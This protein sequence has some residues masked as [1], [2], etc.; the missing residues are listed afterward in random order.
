MAGGTLRRHCKE[1]VSLEF[2]LE[3]DTHCQSPGSYALHAVATVKLA[4]HADRRFP[5]FRFRRYDNRAAA[6]NYRS[7]GTANHEQVNTI[8]SFLV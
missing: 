8:S 2:S 6:L 7:Y 1:A 5:M 4:K 3:L